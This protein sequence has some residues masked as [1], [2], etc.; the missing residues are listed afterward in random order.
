MNSLTSK[1]VLDALGVSLSDIP[2]FKGAYVFPN[3]DVAR[4]DVRILNNREYDAMY[5][6]LSQVPEFRHVV[7]ADDDP[8]YLMF[9]FEI[10]KS[11]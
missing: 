3:D 9:E 2:T 1:D 6:M 7:K 5:E 4:I 8:R 10:P 11:L